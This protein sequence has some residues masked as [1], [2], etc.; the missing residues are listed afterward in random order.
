MST[1]DRSPDLAQAMAMAKEIEQMANS[2]FAGAFSAAPGAPGPAV[3]A[4]APE[5]VSSAVTSSGAVAP[6]RVGPHALNVGGGGISPGT[7]L[8]PIPGPVHRPPLAAA[9]PPTERDLRALPALLSEN[10]GTPSPIEVAS[11]ATTQ[12]AYGSSEP[13]FLQLAGLPT[14]ASA[15]PSGISAGAVP[16][17]PSGLPFAIPTHAGESFQ[18]PALPF[19]DERASAP[20]VSSP[21]APA[22]SAP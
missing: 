15:A 19:V 13:Y 5:A 22:V 20:A 11:F 12:D 10:L 17:A 21:A 8:P 7:A 2:F 3:D 4:A 18:V 16:A 9:P 1:S 14:S 6:P